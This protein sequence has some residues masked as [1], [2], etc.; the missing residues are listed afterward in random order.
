MLWTKLERLTARLS[1]RRCPG[2]GRAGLI[3]Y[4]PS[5]TESVELVVICGHGISTLLGTCRFVLG[6][7]PG[8]APSSGNRTTSIGGHCP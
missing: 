7:M 3:T 5:E 6:L 4:V 2:C 1:K 8:K